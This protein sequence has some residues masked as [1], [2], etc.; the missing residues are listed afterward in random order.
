[1]H[2][3]LRTFGA[4]TLEG[5]RGWGEAFVLRTW[6]NRKMDFL[7]KLTGSVSDQSQN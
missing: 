1:M 6:H 5:S 7:M 3:E 4:Y 2:T